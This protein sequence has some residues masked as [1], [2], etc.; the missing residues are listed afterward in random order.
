[1]SS[2]L[3]SQ[4]D[5]L[6]S[7]AGLLGVSV[8]DEQAIDSRDAMAAFLGKDPK[9]LPFLIEEARTLGL[10]VGDWKYVHR[11][12]KRQPELYDLSQDPGE[13]TDLADEQPERVAKM[14]EQLLRLRAKDG[15]L[16][17]TRD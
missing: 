9:G 13:T 5:L 17:P 15:R 6:A 1:M 10:R 8:P 2:A 16:R 3:V 14:R 11:T 7:F 4:I 12:G